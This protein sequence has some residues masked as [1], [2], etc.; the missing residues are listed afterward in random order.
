M[1]KVLSI[2]NS[3]ADN[4]TSQIEKFAAADHF[5]LFVGKANIG[6]CSLEKHWNLVEQCDLISSVKPYQF[7]RTGKETIPATLKEALCAEKWDY[8]TLQQVSDY[9]YRS[10][11]YF[12]YIEK[13]SAFVKQ[14]APTAE[15]LIHQTWAYRI[16][17]DE[18]KR[19]GINQEE[20]HL[21]LT[22]AY[23]IASEKLGSLRILPNGRAM[24]LA[25]ALF[26]FVPDATFDPSQ[27]IYPNLPN[28]EKALIGGYHWATGATP[29]GKP[30]LINDGR[31]C[32]T[33]GCY[34]VGAL[35]YAALCGQSLQNNSYRPDGVSEEEIATLK[36]CAK[37]A[38]TEFGWNR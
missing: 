28:Q 21:L 17:S 34:L 14:Y 1:I 29:T 33:K 35:W 31:H 30:T 26:N 2:G 20:M 11:T 3:F 9:S 13:L 4:A 12:P 37:Q 36:N 16:D 7:Y 10:S 24:E 32:N 6:G 8:I 19:Y 27:A 25:T 5:D 22:R 18:F 23:Q 38:L 15:Q